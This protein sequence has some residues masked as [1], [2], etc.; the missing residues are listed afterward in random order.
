MR[1]AAAKGTVAAGVIKV[2]CKAAGGSTTIAGIVKSVE[3]AQARTAPVQK[4]ADAGAHS[5]ALFPGIYIA[6]DCSAEAHPSS[7]STGF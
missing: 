5:A 6:F 7:I 3:E 2:E 1:C 4:M